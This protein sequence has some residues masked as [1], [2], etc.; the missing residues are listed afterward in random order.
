MAENNQDLQKQINDIN[1]KLDL[2]LEHVNKQRLKSEMVDDLVAD[3]S[4]ITKDAWDTTVNEL[5]DQGIELDVDDIKQLFF[6]FL[7]NIKSFTQAIELFES[8]NDFMKDAGPIVNE[9]GVDA[10]HKLHE[11]EQKGYFEFFSEMGK[12]MDKVV[13]HYSPEDVRKLGENIIPLMDTVSNM[14]RP[15]MLKTMNNA[16]NAYQEMENEE[17]ED[18]SLWKAFRTLN[19][20]EMRKNIGFAMTFMKKMAQN[21]NNQKTNK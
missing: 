10:I 16:L 5:D 14:T 19:S 15:E 4:I 9:I 8:T 17:I 18:Y 13:T 1:Q 3:A 20:K 11:F 2:V 6:K 12:V 21:S 7:K